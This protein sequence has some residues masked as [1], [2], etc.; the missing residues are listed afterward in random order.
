MS[1]F[2]KT[3]QTVVQTATSTNS[4]GGQAPLHYPE[5]INLSGEWEVQEEDK[6]YRATLDDR[7]NGSYTWQ[8]GIFETS[9]LSDGLWAGTWTQ[10]GNDREGGFEVL[11]STDLN[12]AQGVWWYT[13]VGE[14]HNIPPREWGGSYIM[15][16]VNVPA[17]SNTKP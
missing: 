1:L 16:R 10:K 2:K 6:S 8:D 5:S 15:K 4:P 9:S 12:T 3:I 17:D 7:G 13:R 11:L 14:H